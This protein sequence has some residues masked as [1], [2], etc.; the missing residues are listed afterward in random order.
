M[1]YL[2]PIEA[3]SNLTEGIQKLLRFRDEDLCYV[4]SDIGKYDD[5]LVPFRY[6]MEEI[7]ASGGFA[8]IILN[9]TADVLYFEPEQTR[10]TSI[11]FIGRK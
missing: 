1:R 3:P 7:D 4:I 9:T 8:T 11:R 6:F 2:T 10:G 5:S